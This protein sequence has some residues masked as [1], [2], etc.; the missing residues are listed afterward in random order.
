MRRLLAAVLMSLCAVAS[1]GCEKKDAY[2][3]APTEGSYLAAGGLKYQIQDSRELNPSLVEDRAYLR[4]LPADERKLTK[5]QTWFGVWLR[6]ENDSDR[7]L[8][9]AESF[10]ITDTLGK[11]YSPEPSVA[12]DELGYAATTLPP[13]AILPNQDSIAGRTGPLEGALLLFKIEPS[14]YQN[15]PLEFRIISPTDPTRVAARVQLDV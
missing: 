6:V 1:A 11:V 4:R 3:D 12:G 8:R 10:E 2:T 15:R 9:S 14:A 7:P 5:N 13:A